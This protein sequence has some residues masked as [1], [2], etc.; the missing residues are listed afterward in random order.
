MAQKEILKSIPSGWFAVCFSHELLPGKMLSRVFNEND[1][2]LFRTKQGVASALD[3]YCPHLGAHLGHGGTV[4]SN[5]LQC[6]FHGLCFNTNGNCVSHD[7]NSTKINSWPIQEVDGV[8]Y[9]YYGHQKEKPSWEVPSIL[10][11]GSWGA[12]VFFT[13][14]DLKTHPQDWSENAIDFAHLSYLHGFKSTNYDFKMATKGPYFKIGYHFKSDFKPLGIKIEISDVKTT[15][16]SHGL[17]CAVIEV[18]SESIGMIACQITL[19]TMTTIGKLDLRVVG[20]ADTKHIEKLNPL[21]KFVPQ[22]WLNKIIAK[23][24]LKVYLKNIEQDIDILSN[25]T[26]VDK[27]TQLPED[28]PITEYRK[29]TKQFYQ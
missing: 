21:L 22:K 6:P 14:I 3:A 16:E 20:F 19:P 2:V 28:G 29:W 10:K 25:R 26:L 9:L 17:G 1:I 11:R 5:V 15:I 13:Y 7:L 27:L 24:V 18:I 8:I 23:S 4:K 12:P